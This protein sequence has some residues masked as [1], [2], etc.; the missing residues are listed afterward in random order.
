MAKS[1]KASTVSDTYADDRW[2]GPRLKVW[3]ESLKIEQIELSERVGISQ[4][5]ISYI[6]ND[7]TKF[8]PKMRARVWTALEALS[9][10]HALRAE[11]IQ[12]GGGGFAA[13]VKTLREGVDQPALVFGKTPEECKDLE[14]AM[15]ATEVSYL[16]Q[17]L[18]GKDA[19]ITTLIKALDA[20][21]REA[22]PKTSESD[23]TRK[24]I[25]K[26]TREESGN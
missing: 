19:Q 22:V 23:A 11:E 17:Q 7:K 2:N 1:K 13:I 5:M 16:K 18:A 3:R 4:A 8:T 24:A 12:N 10:E 25:A 21:M 20:A 6:E 15:L 14:I 26:L 9:R